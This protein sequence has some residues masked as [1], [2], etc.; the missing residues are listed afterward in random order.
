MENKINIAEILKDCPKGMELDCTLY[1]SKVCFE[2]LD[3]NNSAYP[4]KISIDLVNI[5]HL[6]IYGQYTTRDYSKCVIFPKGKTTWEGFQKPFKDG[7]VVT[8]KLKGC[9]VAF[10]YKERIEPMLVKTHFVLYAQNMGFCID[11]ELTLKEEDIRLAT[12]EEK[13]KLFEAIKDNGYKWNAET[14]TLEKLIKPKFIVGDT[15]KSKNDKWQ[16]KR[17]IQTYVRGIGYFTTIND[18]IR[19]DDQDEWERVPDKFDITTLKPFDKVL[20]RNTETTCW[21]PALFGKRK[22]Y[23]SSNF[24]TSAG[25]ATFCIPYEN[26][27]HLLGS[28]SDCDE[29]YKTWEE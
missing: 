6:D 16:V 21:K 19:I 24:I 11:T 12:E 20:I 3:H 8:Y 13:E 18:W 17:T 9:M 7:D 26:N 27:E 2:G 23:K 25:F 22:N 29:Y 1:N 5:E 4:I 28:I 10:I 14:K 15:V